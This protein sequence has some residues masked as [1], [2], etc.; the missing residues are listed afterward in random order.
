MAL[1]NCKINIAIIYTS[2]TGNTKEL[3]DLL[4]LLFRNNSIEAA[5][6]TADNFPLG[7]LSAFDAIVIG[8][9]TWGNGELPVEMQPIYEA[10]EKQEVKEVVTGVVGTGDSFYP[11]FC[12]AVDVFRDML[13]I[14]TT[15]ATTLK[16]ELSPQSKD[17]SRCHKFVTSLLKHFID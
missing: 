4:D 12:G 16:I 1:M 7:Q 11:N 10:F 14:Q 17:L 15:L 8:T 6:Y 5:V 13:M 9:Y 2:I 3:I